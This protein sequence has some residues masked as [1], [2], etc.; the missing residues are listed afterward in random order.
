M[1]NADSHLTPK[2]TWVNHHCKH[3]DAINS[4]NS[5]GSFYLAEVFDPS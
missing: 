2:K 4:G 5:L 3:V 1:I